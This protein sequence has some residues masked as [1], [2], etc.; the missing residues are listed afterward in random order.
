M[1]PGTVLAGSLFWYKVFPENPCRQ[2]TGGSKDR[3]R[4]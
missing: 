3:V 4:I 2:S 1:Q